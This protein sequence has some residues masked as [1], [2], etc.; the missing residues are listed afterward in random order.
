MWSTYYCIYC[1]L[2][3]ILPFFFLLLSF[4]EPIRIFD[5]PNLFWIAKT[6]YFKLL[7]FIVLNLAMWIRGIK[8]KVNNRHFTVL[9]KNS[10]DITHTI[11]PYIILVLRLK[12]SVFSKN[13][14][15]IVVKSWF[16]SFVD[17]LE[18]ELN[19]I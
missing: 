13:V 11:F 6:L 2:C 14:Y 17:I 5:I 3:L 18:R 8:K 12:I 4:H 7:L 16:D 10:P 9:P 15:N 19:I 1:I